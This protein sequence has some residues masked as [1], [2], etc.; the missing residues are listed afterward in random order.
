MLFP[1]KTDK[2]V[3]GGTTTY[4]NN[5]IAFISG[6]GYARSQTRALF[7]DMHLKQDL[8]WLLSGLSVGFQIGI[9]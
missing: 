2:G 8:S 7:A 9:R 3:W 1:C 6:S 4:S 5:P